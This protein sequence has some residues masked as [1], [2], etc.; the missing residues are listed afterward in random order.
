MIGGMGWARVVVTGLLVGCGAPQR[1]SAP[2]KAD[3]VLTNGKIYTGDP[4]EPRVQA[5]GIRGDRGVAIGSDDEISRIDAPRRIDLAGRLVIPGIND[6]HVHEPALD[7]GIAPDGT[8]T[9]MIEVPGEFET[10]TAAELL[11]ALEHAT[12]EHP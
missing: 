11:A 3:I 6:A 5:L 4:A 1:G 12:H 9:P 10:Q 8:S 7:V 2:A